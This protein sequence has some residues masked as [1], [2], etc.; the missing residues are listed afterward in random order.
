MLHTELLEQRAG[1]IRNWP[2]F[3]RTVAELVKTHYEVTR[4]HITSILVR[5][6]VCHVFMY[7]MYTSAMH[8]CLYA[9]IYARI[10]V[11]MRA[12]IHFDYCACVHACPGTIDE[13]MTTAPQASRRRLTGIL[14]PQFEKLLLG[15]CD[16]Q[17]AG[18]P[19]GRAIFLPKLVGKI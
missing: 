16:Q 11:R 8:T 15:P 9:Q 6:D 12:C 10:Y 3:P 5:L 1:R 18:S 4:T 7:F 13:E 17:S 14:Q 19:A 2:K